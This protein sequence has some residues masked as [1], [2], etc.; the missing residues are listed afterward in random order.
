MAK[1][2][3]PNPENKPQ[4]N[5]IDGDKINNHVE[6]LEWATAS[7]N[8]THAFKTGLNDYVRKASSKTGFKNGIKARVLTF[9]QAETIRR[10]YQSGAISS[11]KLAK[12]YGVGQTTILGILNM[13]TYLN[14]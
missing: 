12:Q 7:E 9:K 3:I 11:R 4:V 2:F 14:E 8:V 6:N 13:K 5:H 10:E 1:A